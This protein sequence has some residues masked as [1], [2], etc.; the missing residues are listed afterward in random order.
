MLRSEIMDIFF[1][2][3]S[4][5]EA[6]LETIVVQWLG[7]AYVR[8]RFLSAKAR[9]CMIPSVITPIAVVAEGD[10][11]KVK[12]NELHCSQSSTILRV[13]IQV[14]HAGDETSS[15]LFN[16][17]IVLMLSTGLCPCTSSSENQFPCRP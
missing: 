16:A 2:I 1:Q 15:L 6:A 4:Q 17:G 9:P 8:T 13:A 3:E 5:D 12:R 7:D 14:F 11:Q 10:R